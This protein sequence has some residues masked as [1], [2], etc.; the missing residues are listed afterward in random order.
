MEINKNK[1][2][3]IILNCGNVDLIDLESI[4]NFSATPLH[5]LASR[6]R[7]DLLKKL[8]F[9]LRKMNK[10]KFLVEDKTRLSCFERAVSN[11]HLESFKYLVE[12]SEIQLNF[13]DF[14]FFFYF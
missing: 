11:G 6:G 8:D 10:K 9:K 2:L 4:D 3:E 5:Y 1:N 14:F 13:F 12:K 7:I